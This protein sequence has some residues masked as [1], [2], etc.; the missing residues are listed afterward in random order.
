[1]IVLRRLASIAYWILRRDR[2]EQ[3]LDE[4]IRSFV[5][6]SAAERIR[7]GVPPAE[8]RRLA[9]ADLGGLEQV[10]EKVRSG[11]HG[12]VLDD[13]SRDVRYAFR[14]FARQP[15]FAA[16]IVGTLALGIGAN[17]AIFSIL[18][19]LL[20]RAL[21]IADPG[22][23]AQLVTPPPSDQRSWTYPIWREIQRQGAHFDGVFAWTTFDAEFDLSTG[24]ESRFVNGAWASAAAFDV[25][26][27]KPALGRLFLPSDDHPGGGSGG[28]V[29]VISHAFWQTHFAGAPDV[30]GRTLTLERVP[31][32]VAGVTPAEFFGMTPGRSLD[33][34]VPLGAEPLIRGSESRVERRTS[35]WL[36]VFVR[37]KAGQSRDGAATVL[38]TTRPAIR[39]ATMPPPSPG[40][41]LDGYLAD[42]FVFVDAAHGLSGIRNSYS[43]P[44]LILMVVVGLVLL[45]ACANI[46]NLL[47]A[48]ATARSH[49]WS[50]RLALGA[51]RPRLARQLVIE[52]LLLA[53]I[54]TAAGVAVAHWGSRLLV[55]QLSTDAVS[56]EL[57]LDARLLAFTAAVGLIAALV[58]GVVP[59]WRATRGAP[60]DALNARGRSPGASGHTPMA[61]G[62][63]LVQVTLSV[64][65][66]VAAG[67]FLRS[68]DR[69]TRV[70]LGFE[71]GHVLLAVID[72]RR[73]D[74]APAA[75]L[76]AYEQIHERVLAVPGVERAAVS[77]TAPLGVMWSRRIDV[78]GSTLRGSDAPDVGPEGFGFTDRPIPT[79]VPLAVFNGITSG[80]I[81]TF[82]TPL[83][84]GRDIS[85]DDGPA[86]P[87]VALVNQAFAKKFLDGA[88]PVGHT[89]RPMRESDSPIEIVGLVA[90]A[91]YR[92]LREPA[93]PTAYV[94]LS[95]ATDRA[96]GEDP[97][98]TTPP[99]VTLSVRAA[100]DRAGLLTKSIAAAIGEV[101]PTLA[102]TFEPLDGR[103][104]ATLT[105][106]RL[107]AIL[108]AA[109]GVLA[110]LMASIGL[111]GVTS[112]AVNLRRTEIGIRMALGATRG[113]VIRLVLGRLGLLVGGGTVAGL[114]CAAWLS[115]FAATLLYALEPGDPVTLVASA[116][117]LALV[118][119]VAGWLPA[120]HASRL[121]PTQVL[122]EG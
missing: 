113:A 19:G 111:Y 21:P 68:F 55:A 24:G 22:R 69:L 63:V 50:V 54:G 30:I 104:D 39:E 6:M 34:V 74:L 108:S 4:E 28:P 87:R 79:N 26:G 122:R 103:V 102:L 117:T 93:L 118:G 105:R 58:F 47:L 49:E 114:A 45:I 10:K 70:P 72:A 62:L 96:L 48:R 11:R 57:P 35:W 75:R 8:A 53:A 60:I 65:L 110:L 116:A 37:L 106:E 82:G 90:D 13:V 1:M 112:Y 46:A 42:P 61:N 23:L 38:E 88:N 89:I 16:V 7:E 78:S 119:A 91:V 25:L 81:A 73:A 95:Q 9:L 44:L 5:E 33:V 76:A 14:L 94:P 59:A 56:L 32:T 2:A 27:V 86:S 41:N 29:V 12:A 67:L 20:L 97:T 98:V 71:R 109:F 85:T 115:R 84:A 36:Q 121:D 52:S 17:T 3:Q 107:L 99:V 51:S 64:V 15:T 77:I 101:N 40:R 31:L 100:S 83:L 18:D 92:D 120:R 66:L 80:W 43:R